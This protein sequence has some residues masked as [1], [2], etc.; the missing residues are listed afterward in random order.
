MGLGWHATA[1]SERTEPVEGLRQNTPSVHAF[2]GATVVISPGET[3]ENATLVI[4]NGLIESVGAGISVPTDARVW[5][6]EGKTIYAGFIDAH[7]TVGQQNPRT[8]SERGAV[9]WNPQLRSHL[10]AAGE[11]NADGDGAGALRSQGFTAA[12]SVPTLGIWRGR[13]A[14]V[15]LNEGP[16]RERLLRGEVAQSLSLRRSR[17]LGTGYPT[18]GMGA[19]AFIRQTFLDADWHDRARAAHAENPAGTPRPETNAALAALAPAARG[20]QPILLEALSDDEIL[21]GLRLAGEFSFDLWILGS[22]HEYRIADVLAEAGRP[23]ILPVNFPSTPGAATPEEALGLSLEELRH[24]HLAPENPA[25]LAAAGIP[26]ALTTHGLGRPGNF[27]ANLRKAVQRGLD[28]ETALEALTTRPAALLGLE[29]THGTLEAGKAANFIVAEG[30]L[31]ASGGKV[32]DVWV[33]GVRHRVGD[34][35]EIDARGEWR[36]VSANRGVEGTLT[37]GGR[38]DRLTGTL[39]IGE[40]RIRTERPRYRSDGRRLRVA[41][42]G[43]KLGMEG[44]VRLSAIVSRETLLGW[45]ELPDGERAEW[46]GERVPRSE[47]DK[48]DETPQEEEPDDERDS[49]DPPAEPERPQLADIRPAM[50]Y[51][52]AA[53]P[54]SPEHVLVR[55]ATIWTM[56]ED[57]VLEEADLLVSRGKVVQ[58][59]RG[60][61]APSGAVEIDAEG[62]HVTPGLID[63]HLHAGVFGGVNEVG[64]AVVPEVRIG[65]VLHLNNIWMYRQIAGGLTTAH[66]MHGS[67]NPIGGQNQTIKLRWGQLPEKLKFEDAPR[68]VKFALGENVKR[69]TSRYPN[70]RMGTEQIIADHF[71]AA[72]DYQS[73]RAEWETNPNGVPPRRDLRLE[74]IADML[75]DDILIQC[76]SYRQ[77]EILMLMRLSEDHGFHIKA[78]HHGVEAYKVAPELADYG[79][80]AVVWTDWSSFKIEAYDATTR[81]A[82]LLHEAGVLTSLHSDN[83]QIAT[84]MNWEAAKMVRAGMEEEDALALVTLNTAKLLGIDHRVGS[85]EPGKDADF[86]IWN[87]HPL[88]TFTRADQTWIDGRKYFDIDEDREARRQ[89]ER[90]RAALLQLVLKNN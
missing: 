19:I 41:F 32:V 14:A 30:D 26:F 67:A 71:R 43:E 49:G 84:R 54:D 75:E 58:I 2:T 50:E 3:L 6:L 51:G 31:F 53:P 8:E 73:R 17:E 28:P 47:E 22:G 4:R 90:E 45:A 77:D 48:P 13:A 85:L 87:G 65:D 18:S 64:H 7:A 37:I 88:S 5:D 69:R 72:R 36:V 40:E 52:R 62:R 74:A 35:D 39:V 24:W 80:G 66:V 34:L 86:V 83:N 1:A 82:R 42:P 23:L 9:S 55:N 89:V 16:V 79:A 20:E 44:T 81:N 63:A 15:S 33:D 68:T 60:I 59:G 38:P 76:H 46:T 27:L 70:T 57:G 78:F 61:A 11:Y 12:L 10:D 25:R 29:A 21:R 56:G